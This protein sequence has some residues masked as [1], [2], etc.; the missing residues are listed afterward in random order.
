MLAGALGGL[1]ALGACSS[2]ATRDGT[3]TSRHVSFQPRWRLAVPS[4]G[5]PI[6]LLVALHGYGGGADDAFDHV[7]LGEHVDRTRL[8]VVS[9]DGGNTY[10]HQRRDGTDAGAMVTDDLIPLALR[11]AGLAADAPVATFGWSMGGFGALHL[12]A[13]LGPKRIRAI[14]GSS[15]ALWMRAGDTPQGAFDDRED[16]EKHTILGRAP[17]LRGSH[18]WL[19]CGTS[20]PFIKA[21]RELARRLPTAK[22]VFDP[23]GHDDEYWSGHAGAQLDWV[24]ER[25][26]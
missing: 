3:L 18:V 17:K 12:G 1:V 2:D 5:A 13:S 26:S 24:A 23:G 6:G 21:N 20:D 22:A 9:V 14:V 19:S 25:L 10:W 15:S 8:A 7:G 16:Y 4:S 11:E